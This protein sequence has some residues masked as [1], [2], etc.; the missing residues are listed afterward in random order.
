MQLLIHLNRCQVPSADPTI[1]DAFHRGSIART[2]NF[3]SVIATILREAPLATAFAPLAS[4]TAFT[5]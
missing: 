4:H 3:N 2:V 1:Q 5:I